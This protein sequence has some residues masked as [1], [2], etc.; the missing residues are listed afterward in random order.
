MIDWYLQLRALLREIRVKAADALSASQ[1]GGKDAA[2]PFNEY[3]KADCEKLKELWK[4]EFP[5]PVP[6]NLGRHV[7]FGAAQDYEDILRCDLFEVEQGADERLR[8]F[9]NEKGALGFEHL[10]HPAVEKYAY[11]QYRHGQYRDAVLN[12]VI[13]VF[14][15]IR[16]RS[17]SQADGDALVGEVFSLDRPRLVFS[18]LESE[19]GKNDQKGFMQILRGAYQGIRNPKAHTLAH[20]LEQTKAAQH[21]VFASLLA[22]RVEEC[23]Q[24]T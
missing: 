16:S 10:L 15:L 21:L 18:E 11:E 6:S 9:S 3:L 4:H 5:T 13:A 24:P 17:G 8:A 14:D 12:S 22:R 1:G 23:K 7:H 20:D 19:S 2:R